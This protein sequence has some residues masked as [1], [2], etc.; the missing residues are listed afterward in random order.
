[1]NVP[2]QAK[3][4]GIPFDRA[5]PV[6]SLHQM[7]AP[8]VATIEIDRV[9]RLDAMHEG[10]EIRPRCFHHQMKVVGHQA[11]QVH[12]HLET[13]DTLA[14]H[15]EESFPI[16]IILKDRLPC[17]A[18]GRHMVHGPFVLDP[19]RPCHARI[20]PTCLPSGNPELPR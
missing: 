5:G 11:E 10:P 19:L 16:G 12:T 14:Q 9:R 15:P 13:P 8:R 6:P 1:M 4:V 7:A 3:H 17:I 18:P 20:L 2:A